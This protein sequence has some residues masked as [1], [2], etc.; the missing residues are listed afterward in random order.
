MLSGIMAGAVSGW[1]FGVTM[2]A[3]AAGTLWL[4]RRLGWLA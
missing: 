2:F 3:G 1:V 4:G